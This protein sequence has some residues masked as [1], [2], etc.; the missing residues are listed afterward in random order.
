MKT[1]MYETFKLILFDLWKMAGPKSKTPDKLLFQI[2]YSSQKNPKTKASPYPSVPWTS[3]SCRCGLL[4]RC[5]WKSCL[6]WV[7]FWWE[8]GC[9]VCVCV[10]LNAQGVPSLSAELVLLNC[11][12]GDYTSLSASLSLCWC[13]CLKLTMNKSAQGY[14][15]SQHAMLWLLQCVEEIAELVNSVGNKCWLVWS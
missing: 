8:S 14:I 6:L 12:R 3:H 10:C 7:R 2:K 15:T 9:S 1:T 5:R 13:G 4:S 11:S